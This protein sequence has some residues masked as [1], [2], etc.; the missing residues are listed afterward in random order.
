MNPYKSHLDELFQRIIELRHIAS[1]INST[2]TSSIKTYADYPGNFL[3]GSALVLR[4]WTGPTDN[5]WEFC[6]HTGF[7]QV[8]LKDNYEN[9]INR[10]ISQECCFAYAQSFEGLEKFLKDCAFEIEESSP[11]CIFSMF[12]RKPKKFRRETIGGDR[13]FKFIKNAGDPYFSSYSSKNHRDLRFKELW[14][15]LSECRHAIIHNKSKINLKRLK[16]TDYHLKIF[17][18]LFPNSHFKDNFVIIMLD[19]MGLSQLLEIVSEFAFQV[20][21][22]ISQKENLDWKIDKK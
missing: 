17:K 4:D 2:M 10:I 9:E 19:F 21:K 5:G 15:I 22:S 13:L 12:K 7:R 6:F 3:T 16:K 1:T 11:K 20:Y 14:S 8:T 18:Y